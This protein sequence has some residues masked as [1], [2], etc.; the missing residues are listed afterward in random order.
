MQPSDSESRGRRGRRGRRGTQGD[1]GEYEAIHPWRW[2]ALTLWII[3]FTIA[4]GFALHD[5]RQLANANRKRI[6]EIQQARVFS[7]RKTYSG[8]EEVFNAVFLPSPKKQN[9][10]QKSI[11]KKFHT[12][13]VN[14]Q[15]KCVIQTKVRSK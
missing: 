9:T 12:E 2:R 8:V 3:V 11:S 5:S 10:E 6:A 4:V 1:S 13:V 15:N 14:L 7:C